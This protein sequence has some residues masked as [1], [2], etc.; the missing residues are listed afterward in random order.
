MADVDFTYGSITVRL[1]GVAS[2]CGTMVQPSSP[3]GV[4]IL[5]Y[6]YAVP[7]TARQVINPVPVNDNVA[8][9]S[10]VAVG[11]RLQALDSLVVLFTRTTRPTPTPYSAI[12]ESLAIVVVPY[13]PLT[14]LDDV[15]IRPTAIGNPNNSLVAAMRGAPLVFDNATIGSAL[16]LPDCSISSS[17][18]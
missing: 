17:R 5:S 10:T 7:G 1:G 11:T 2:Y 3:A 14:G 15:L 6:T 13:G 4:E 16:V 12:D 18:G 8:I 9:T